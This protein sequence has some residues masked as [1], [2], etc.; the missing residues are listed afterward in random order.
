MGR[1]KVEIRKIENQTNR[2]V[3]FSKR[4]NGIIKKSYE[5]STLCDVDVGVLMFSPSGRLSL[6]SAKKRIEDILWRFVNLPVHER[7]QLKNHE[8]LLRILEN[9]KREEE[10]LSQ[11]SSISNSPANDQSAEIVEYLQHEIQISQYQIEDLEKQLRV[12]EG[13]PAEISSLVEVEYHEQ[14]LEEA[15]ERIRQQK[16]V[17]QNKFSS[18]C[19]EPGIHQVYSEPE[20]GTMNNGL[21]TSHNNVTNNNIFDDEWVSVSNQ[22]DEPRDSNI[23]ILNFLNSNGLLP[24]RDYH[25][26]QQTVPSLQLVDTVAPPSAPINVNNCSRHYEEHHRMPGSMISISRNEDATKNKELVPQQQLVRHG[27]NENEIDV[28]ELP[29]WTAELMHHASTCFD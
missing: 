27:Y 10:I 20:S 1:T 7:G 18:G 24:I 4:R 22:N 26:Q 19:M 3:T 5:L 6:F 21:I 13:N 14:V 17:L 2:Q 25:H 16:D 9:L 23:Q 11:A 28:N 15:L 29:P 12:F 8:F